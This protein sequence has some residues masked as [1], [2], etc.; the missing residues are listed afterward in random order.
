MPQLQRPQIPPS[1]P[2]PAPKDWKGIQDGF[3]QNDEYV[4]LLVQYFQKSG[5]NLY[6]FLVPAQFQPAVIDQ[7]QSPYTPP[8]GVTCVT[9][10]VGATND[11]TVNLPASS[12]GGRILIFKNNNATHNMVINCVGSDTIDGVA[13]ETLSSQYAILRLYDGV[14][15]QWAIW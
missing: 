1:K 13:S 5:L 8:V 9:L 12:G 6:N 2:T 11:V 10:A 15:G 7:S 14:V 4:R 3:K